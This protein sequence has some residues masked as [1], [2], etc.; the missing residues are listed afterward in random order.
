M[1]NNERLKHRTRRLVVYHARHH[2]SFTDP[3]LSYVWLSDQ[4]KMTF[5]ML[6]LWH[7]YVINIY[8]TQSSVQDPA[9]Q[10]Q[11]YTGYVKE[12]KFAIKKLRCVQDS[13]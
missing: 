10:I 8:L 3:S 7:A 11:V 4:I 6:S 13:T 12:P 5:V 9:L 2:I 1:R